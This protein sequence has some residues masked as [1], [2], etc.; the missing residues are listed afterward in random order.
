MQ[1]GTDTH[2]ME[3]FESLTRQELLSCVELGKA[4]TGE[5]DSKRLF[6]K[7]LKKVSEL[8]PAENWSLLLLDEASGELRFELSVDLTPDL[9]KHI[10]LRLGEGIA[11]QVALRQV[12]MVI[13]DV[14]GCEFF[15]SRVDDLSGYKTKSLI[16]VPLVFGGKTLGV[17]EVINPKSMGNST[18]P[19]L[20]IIADYAAI[21][22]ENMRQYRHINDLAVHDDLTG[23]FNQRYLYRVLR[24]LINT[25]A[26]NNTPFSLVFMDLDNFKRVVDTYGHLKGSE[27]LQ[28]VAATIRACLL[29]PA[30]G[31]AYGGDEFVIVLPG[32]GKKI[33]V[34]KAEEIRSQMSQNKYLSKYGHQVAIQ[35]SFGLATYPDDSTDLSDLLALADNAMFHAKNTGKDAVIPVTGFKP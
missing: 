15:S 33:A 35:A 23:L 30:F 18:L 6:G 16:C 8:L 20:S 12:P 29:D 13:D 21:A 25:S 10:R 3:G 31:V 32:F 4:L 9:L 28:E 24:H 22:V 7:I 11:G 26:V 17:I 14:G 5:L 34:H 1:D 19:L 27:A 2:L